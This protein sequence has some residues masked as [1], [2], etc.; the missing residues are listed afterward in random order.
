VNE[1]SRTFYFQVPLSPP[2]VNHYLLT[3][4]GGGRRLSAEA[5]AFK[6][7][8][9]IFARQLGGPVPWIHH[10]VTVTYGLGPQ[11]R[12][13]VDNATKLV[14]DGLQASGLIQNDADVLDL[15]QY[16]RR[17]AQARQAFTAVLVTEFKGSEFV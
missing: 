11:T 4:R 10:A 3:N 2:S 9:V 5:Q 13:D 6:D 16:K 14:L 8:V 17:V 1:M 15:V 7:A 12:L